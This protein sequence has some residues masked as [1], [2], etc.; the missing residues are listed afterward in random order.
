MQTANDNQPEETSGLFEALN[1]YASMFYPKPAKTEQE[2][3]NEPR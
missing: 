1:A 2:G 3:D